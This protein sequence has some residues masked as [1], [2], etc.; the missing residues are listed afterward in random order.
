[1]ESL[2]SGVLDAMYSLPVTAMLNTK[3]A[4]VSKEPYIPLDTEPLVY[5][6]LFIILG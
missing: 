4:Y 3:S 5:V 2:S 1:M 6:G